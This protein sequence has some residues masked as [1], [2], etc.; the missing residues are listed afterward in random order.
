MI[1]NTKY[2]YSACEFDSQHPYDGSQAS[3]TP[4]L[5]FSVGTRH[6]R[7]AHTYILAGKTLVKYKKHV[8]TTQ[9]SSA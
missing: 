3:V 1:R 5:L 4:V 2:S 9:L 6:T 7:G 8:I